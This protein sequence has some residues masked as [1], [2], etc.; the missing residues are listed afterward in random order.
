MI[1]SKVH[2]VWL[3]DTIPWAYAFA[4]MSAA[5][6]GELD[7]VILHHSDV[8]K[9]LPAARALQETPGVRLAPMDGPGWMESLSRHGLQG[10]RLADIYR[11]V[12]NPVARSNML[13]AAA[14]VDFGGI[15]LDL[16]TLTV[17][18]LRPLL[19]SRQFVGVEHIVWPHFVRS[20]RSPLL[21]GRSLALSA[22]RSGLRRAPGGYR[23]FP[24]ISA[25]YYLG[26]N[27]AILGG[28][29]GSPFLCTYLDAMCQV[30]VERLLK[31]HALGTHLLQQQA[32][33][34]RGEDLLVHPPELFYPLPPEISE[35]WFRLQRGPVEPDLALYP[36][37]L[38]AHWY[39][40]VRTKPVIPQ[41]SPD[42]VRAHAGSQLYSA[43]VSRLLPQYS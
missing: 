28:E 34:Y 36:Q 15:Y 12:K 8:L 11:T 40:S 20:S 26:V 42:Y 17:R 14:V 18:S 24:K 41:I 43:L 32:D 16:D 2:F 21:W 7:E 31:K 6:H 5:A 30:P 39:A 27:G 19:S 38:V 23:W 4:V 33:A 35:H 22:L 29:P 25:G 9:D 1:P 10:N 13:R 3:G 37:T